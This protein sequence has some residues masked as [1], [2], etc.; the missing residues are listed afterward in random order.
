MFAGD[1]NNN[2]KK[3]SNLVS[4]IINDKIKIMK[5]GLYQHSVPSNSRTSDSFLFFIDKRIRK[6]KKKGEKGGGEIKAGTVRD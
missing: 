4:I 6:R 2:V 3:I 1:N 5:C